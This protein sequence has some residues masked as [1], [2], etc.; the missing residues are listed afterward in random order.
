MPYFYN[1]TDL[2]EINEDVVSVLL[3]ARRNTGIEFV[4]VFVKGISK[5][6]TPEQYA[7]GLFDE[8]QVG[9]HT[10]GKG[11]L[12][13]FVEDTHTLKIEVSYNLES[14]FTDAFCSSLQ[15]MAKTFYAS[16]LFAE[17]FFDILL[18]MELKITEQ[19]YYDNKD[20]IDDLIS[21]V[22][23]KDI[24]WIYLSGGAGII[25]DEYYHGKEN[26]LRLIKQIPAKKIREFNADK[27]VETVFKRYLKSLEEGINYP[28][29]DILLEGSQMRRLEYI[30]SPLD[31]KMSYRGFQKAFPYYI[32]ERG[33]LAVVEFKGKRKCPI[34][35]RRDPNGLWRI[36]ITKSQVLVGPD[37]RR[38]R[39]EAYY[40][41][42]S[43]GIKDR[44]IFQCYLA[45]I[46]ALIP[47]PLD[48]KERI[49]QLKKAIKEEPENASNYFKL[50]EIY[51]WECFWT[52]GALDLINKGLELEPDNV[53]YH[54][55]AIEVCHRGEGKGESER[56]YKEIL[57]YRPDDWRVYWQYVGYCFLT[58]GE[59]KKASDVLKQIMN[60]ETKYIGYPKFSY[61]LK[62]LLQV[63]YWHV[64]A[65]D[66]NWFYRTKEYFRIFGELPSLNVI[67]FPRALTL[68][69]YKMHPDFAAGVRLMKEPDF[70]LLSPSQ[71]WAIAVASIFTEAH[72]HKHDSLNALEMNEKNIRVIKRM[73]SSSWGITDSK[74]FYSTLQWLD[75]RGHRT[76]F[77][78]IACALMSGENERNLIRRYGDRKVLVVKKYYKELG[79]K[80][81]MGWD[82]IRYVFLCRYAYTAGYITEEEAWQLIIPVAVKMQ[83]TFDS[84]DDLSNNYMIGREFWSYR[85]AK[86]EELIFLQAFERLLNDPDSPWHVYPWDMRLYHTSDIN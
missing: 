73:L 22:S 33:D 5:D 74:S 67:I 16:G 75:Q 13:L 53:F 48:L 10:D 36:D 66:K 6:M 82:Y 51:Y 42:W 37:S 19:F 43:F 12:V 65:K 4:A 15:P 20:V 63:D 35:L 7:T 72:W 24:G 11:V 28:F 41:P 1:K 30:V 58:L 81:I 14:I 34:L 31:Q 86:D 85:K 80:S 47:L 62:G 83:K 46:P 57:K 50:A 23:N 77:N 45:R 52:R 3:S 70:S 56:H 39:L 61:R 40:S 49:A 60:L 32:T 55:L 68:L 54:L 79:D 69:K 29:L 18:M 38:Q 84:W 21:S 2:I 76:D 44:R 17:A 26:K 78:E 25:D 9:K 59:Y 64:M 71:G 8:W 27:D